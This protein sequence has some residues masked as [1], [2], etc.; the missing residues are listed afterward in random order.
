MREPIILGP[1]GGLIH[2]PALK[3]RILFLSS[4]DTGETKK[5]FLERFRW[6]IGAPRNPPKPHHMIWFLSDLVVQFYNQIK[7]VR[8]VI[9]NNIDLYDKSVKPNLTELFF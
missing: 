4:Y 2:P 6:N 1:K 3:L 8:N 7:V 9:L 5:S